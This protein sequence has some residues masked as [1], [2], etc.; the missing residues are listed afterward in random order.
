MF[1]KHYKK[2]LVEARARIELLTKAAVN[3]E[4]SEFFRIS[5]QV[6]CLQNDVKNYNE[7]LGMKK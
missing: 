7:Q 6:T 5:K 1:N 3:S 2:K 4:D